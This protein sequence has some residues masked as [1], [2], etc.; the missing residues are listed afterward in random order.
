MGFDLVERRIPNWLVLSGLVGSIGFSACRGPGQLFECLLGFGAGV[1]LFF[2]PFVLGWM[3]AGDL[4]MFGTAGA[5][6]GIN[7]VPRVFFYTAL[8][9][10]VLGLVAIAYKRGGLNSF[11]PLWSDLKVFIISRGMVTPATV[12]LRAARGQLA[13]PYGVAI[14]MGTLITY[15]LDPRGQWAGF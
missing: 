8:S 1:A 11:K 2:V 3:G 5:I 10:L 6:L 15:Y 4:K 9:G 7:L 12:G 14:A 13:V